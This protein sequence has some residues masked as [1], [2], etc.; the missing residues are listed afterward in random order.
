MIIPDTISSLLSWTMAFL[1]RNPEVVHKIRDEVRAIVGDRIPVY[2]D[3][4]NLK[5]CYMVLKEV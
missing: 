2:E 4:K 3:V 5:Y 1:S